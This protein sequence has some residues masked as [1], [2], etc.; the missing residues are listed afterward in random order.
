MPARDVVRFDV[1]WT[2]GQR[3]LQ[4]FMAVCVGAIAAF[5]IYLVWRN[6]ELVEVRSAPGGILLVGWLP[7]LLVASTVILVHM[8]RFDIWLDGERLVRRG[9]FGLRAIS[10]TTA[11]YGMKETTW[12]YT[13][14]LGPMRLRRLTI[15]APTLV[16][17]SSRLRGIQVPLARRTGHAVVGNRVTVAWLPGD[18]ITALADEIERHAAAPNAGKAALF[19]RRVAASGVQPRG[20]MD[21]PL[22]P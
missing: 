9:A 13:V 12:S 11:T 5:S 8:A 19:L 3:A 18:Q 1:R 21:I 15:A 16:V 6:E 7:A 2:R 4:W 17:R 20:S 14:R 10:L 22:P